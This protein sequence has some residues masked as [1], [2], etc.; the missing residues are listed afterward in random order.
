MIKAKKRTT[1][2]SLYMSLFG[3]GMT[4]AERCC[5][6]LGLDP[7]G[8]VTDFTSMMNKLGV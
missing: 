8:N 3:T 4:T 5:K 1:N 7:D 6:E 2:S